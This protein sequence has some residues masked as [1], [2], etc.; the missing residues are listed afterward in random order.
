MKGNENSQ[1]PDIRI[2]EEDDIIIVELSIPT[3][4][5]TR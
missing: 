4:P 2:V 3:G 1:I 5:R